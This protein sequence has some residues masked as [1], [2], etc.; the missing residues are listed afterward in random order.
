MS[1]LSHALCLTNP[2]VKLYEEEQTPRRRVII[3]GVII[4]KQREFTTAAVVKEK[5][6]AR[7]FSLYLGG[8][9]VVVC[10]LLRSPN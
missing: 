2:R 9:F 1:L 8:F 4:V 10:W 7:I 3:T 5:G 6:S